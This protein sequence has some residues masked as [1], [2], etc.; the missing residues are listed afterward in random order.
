[1]MLP[2]YPVRS[3]LV[4]SVCV[5]TKLMKSM[6][7]LFCCTSSEFSSAIVWMI[8]FFRRQVTAELTFQVKCVISMKVGL[9]SCCFLDPAFRFA[10]VRESVLFR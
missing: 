7:R 10:A 2:G 9:A 1:M 8:T 3:A 4:I 6:P 5:S